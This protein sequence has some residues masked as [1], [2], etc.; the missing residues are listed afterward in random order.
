VA[1]EERVHGLG[2]PAGVHFLER[3]VRT[4]ENERLGLG[5]PLLDAG[6][7]LWPT[8]PVFDALF[9]QD[10]QYGLADALRVLSGKRHVW[11]AGSSTEK[12]VSASATA[13]A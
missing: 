9:P 12:K 4:A 13:C 2:D 7:H 1:G 11:S 6:V 8:R 10:R 5:Q 3:V